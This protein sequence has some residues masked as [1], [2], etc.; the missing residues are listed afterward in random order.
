[1]L[2]FADN[3]SLYGLGGTAFMTQGVYADVNGS[4]LVDDPDPDSTDIVIAQQGSGGNI[5][6]IR[7]VLQNGGEDRVGMA[8]RF[9]LAVLPDNGDQ[10]PVPFSWRDAGNNV[11]GCVTVSTTGTLELR[12]LDV[13]GTILYETPVPVITANGWYHMEC[14]VDFDGATSHVQL[15]VEGRPVI[16]EDVAFTTVTECAQVVT[17]SRVRSNFVTAPPQYVRDWVV[18]SGAGT[19]N[20]DFLGSVVVYALRPESDVDLNWIP[21]VGVAGYPILAQSPPDNAEYITAENP[22]PAPYVCTI[23]D[24]PPDVTSVKGIVAWV[25]AAKSDGGDATIQTGIISDPDGTPDTALGEDRPITTAQTY[26]RDV[27]EEDPK[28]DAPW[29]PSAVNDANLQLNRTS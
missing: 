19:H 7:Y 21:S 29:L 9:W 13:G 3:F 25:R 10:A 14:W 11:I 26:W 27:F 23:T 12:N 16:D 15:R 22:P 1:M 2:L 4:S 5:S 6:R 18:C 28:T 24:L 8:F 17:E 20:T